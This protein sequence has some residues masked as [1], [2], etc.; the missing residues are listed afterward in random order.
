MQIEVFNNP[1]DVVTSLAIFLIGLF[2]IETVRKRLHIKQFVAALIYVW[3]TLFSMAYMAMGFYTQSDSS[4]YYL[5]AL[6]YD[7]Q[8]V[9]GFGTNFVDFLMKQ[10]VTVFSLSYFELFLFFG[11]FGSL[12]LIFFYASIQSVVRNKTK[13]IKRYAPLLVFLPGLSF[14]SSSIGK[15][16]IALL[17]VGLFTWWAFVNK[18]NK[19]IFFSIIIMLLV[20]PHVAA[21]MVIG[22]VASQLFGNGS[23]VLSVSGLI[24]LATSAFI[25]YFLIKYGLKY[26]GLSIDGLNIGILQEYF[27]HRQALNQSGGLAINIQDLTIFEKV[28]AFLFRPLFFDGVSVFI[29]IASIENLIIFLFLFYCIRNTSLRR[30][31]NLKYYLHAATYSVVFIFIMSSVAAN[32]GIALRQKWMVLPVFLLIFISL[33]REIKINKIINN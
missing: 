7:Y 21:M 29:L 14:W 8:P 5:R 6:D 27:Q 16:S 22:L 2:V 9:I 19:I 17:S 12:G 26:S 11:F 33:S 24:T 3:H 15:D 10:L 18:S 32:M 30:V 31:N 4:N 25:G 20:R 28:F 1:I 23:R 13:L